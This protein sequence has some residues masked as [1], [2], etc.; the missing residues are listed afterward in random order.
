MIQQVVCPHCLRTNRVPSE[1]L[2]DQPNCGACKEKL[3]STKPLNLDNRAFNSLISRSDVPVVVDFWASWCGPCQAMAPE[4][5]KAA[6]EL[7]PRW[8][9]AKVNTETEQ[10][11][12]GQFAI[13]SIPTLIVFQAGR[14]VKRM[15][16]ALNAPQL[17]QWLI[18]G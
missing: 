11:I 15:N 7:T 2:G 18:S 5:D 8:I 14:E 10:A 6:A 12:A 3:I 9:F 16:G 4:F 1:R 13:R 17:K